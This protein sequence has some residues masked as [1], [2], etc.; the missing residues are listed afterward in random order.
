MKFFKFGSLDFTNIISNLVKPPPVEKHTNVVKI[1]VWILI[2]T[3]VAYVFYRMYEYFWW[4]TLFTI[5]ITVF[6]FS[7]LGI[8]FLPFLVEVLIGLWAIV[9]LHW[10]G[11]LCGIWSERF[12]N[13]EIHE[14]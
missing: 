10:L 2:A 11:A 3:I 9:L 8:E 4:G 14:K 12:E 5:G 6:L 13:T 1:I 7:P